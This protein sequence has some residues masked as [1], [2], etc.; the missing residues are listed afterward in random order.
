MVRNFLMSEKAIRIVIWTILGI[1]LFVNLG[2]PPFSM[3]EPRRALITLEMQ[4]NDNLIV[5]TQMGEYYY[6]K[7]PMFNWVMM[8]FYQIFGVNEWASR[9]I[10]VFS[11][12][13]LCVMVYRFTAKNFDKET[14][15]YT[16]VFYAISAYIYL[17]FSF[18]G[19]I[20][21]FYA[22]VTFPLLSFPYQWMKKEKYLNVFLFTYG[23]G[24]A[25]LLTKG[26]TSP[27]FVGITLIVLFVYF[28]KIKKLFSL[29]HLAGIL[30]FIGLTSI[31]FIAYHQYNSIEN[32]IGGLW[33]QSSK[34]AP[35]S[36]NLSYLFMRWWQTPLTVIYDTLPASVFLI[37]FA[38]KKVRL[39]MWSDHFLRFV[40]IIFMAN[41]LVYWI[42]PGTRSRYL[43]MLYPF[44]VLL[45]VWAMR[46]YLWDKKWFQKTLFVFAITITGIIL[47]AGWFPAFYSIENVPS[48]IIYPVII[49]A[50]SV[51]SILIIINRKQY[52]IY[53]F[54]F[55]FI[56]VRLALDFYLLPYRVTEGESYTFKKDAGK[57]HSIVGNNNLW[58]LHEEH[59]GSM[60]LGLV[61]YLEKYR[62]TVF[63][64]NPEHNC[65]DFYV[66]HSEEV[67]KEQI[68][69]YYTFSWRLNNYFLIKFTDCPGS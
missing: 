12:L 51:A 18:T 11:L 52:A 3:E 7:P 63:Q 57:I 43:F 58:M 29:E 19:E 25:G 17:Y 54:I 6:R 31:Y 28:K 14:A 67:N 8:V 39:K 68:E 53:G 24:V 65:N 48:G 45:S 66:V 33:W 44:P 2:L 64:K 42:S 22:L 32:Y 60:S 49:S 13:F 15:F 41:F 20:D 69:L 4:Y 5:P 40:F 46:T 36:S 27:V 59:D 9:L 23:L 21:L 16:S 35:W 61:F 62:K 30:L 26:L 55:C 47:I 56:L 10:S 34:K 1:S 50:L 37:L 38:L